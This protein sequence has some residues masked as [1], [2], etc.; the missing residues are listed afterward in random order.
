MYER[1]GAPPSL[2]DNAAIIPLTK[3]RASEKEG[4][5]EGSKSNVHGERV[6]SRQMPI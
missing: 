4:K 2:Q 3:G 1:G 5:G 6:I